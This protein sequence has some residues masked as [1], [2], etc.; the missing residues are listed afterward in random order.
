[1]EEA[2]N[3]EHVVQIPVDKCTLDQV[4]VYTVDRAELSRTVDVKADAAGIYLVEVVGGSLR[5][6][7][8][9]VRVKAPAGANATILEV[10]VERKSIDVIAD[11]DD[12][13]DRAALREDIE[14]LE[15]RLQAIS[16]ED[17]RVKREATVVH[18]YCMGLAESSGDHPLPRLPPSELAKAL[19]FAATRT[20]TVDSRK[21][22]LRK[23]RVLLTK[24]LRLTKEK[25]ANLQPRTQRAHMIIRVRVR[26]DAPT[27]LPLTV[28][29]F[30][31]GAGWAPSF[32]ARVD[33]AS[34]GAGSKGG[35]SNL[36]MQLTYYALVTNNT[37]ED[38]ENC[39]VAL[40][41]A[42]PSAGG[43]PPGV[44]SIEVRW[45]RRAPRARPRP[46]PPPPAAPA[47]H[48]VSC[49][50][51]EMTCNALVA[52]D[53]VTGFGSRA[54]LEDEDDEVEGLAVGTAAVGGGGDTHAGAARFEVEHRTT[55]N[56]SSSHKVTI[57]VLDLEA[58]CHHFTAP[59]VEPCAYLQSKT[60][61]SSP[62]T[63]LKSTNCAVYVDG[64]FVCKSV[65]PQTM[66]GE[67]FTLFLGPDPAV[68]VDC[69]PAVTKDAIVGESIF[70]G[71]GAKRIDARRTV[72]VTNTRSD[73]TIRLHLALTMPRSAD[74]KIKV[75]SIT[76]P[77]QEIKRSDAA[78]SDAAA[79]GSVSAAQGQIAVIQNRITNNLVWILG[80]PAGSKHTVVHEYR[81]EHPA[82]K[83]E[84]DFHELP[85]VTVE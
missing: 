25:L 44:P 37:G 81:V 31:R 8:D 40:S 41:T 52:E 67:S 34:S 80:V 28:A 50:Q 16:D 78:G 20:A 58:A 75:T 64:S 82:D 65:L 18:T 66:P 85:P 1:M 9:S 30:L 46:V 63:L 11:D 73:R 56:D 5:L 57:A 13:P 79:E 39:K 14:A 21:H 27:N 72:L 12:A 70:A 19:D 77:P 48:G 26:V 35:G 43:L 24:E 51:A 42:Q 3:D 32:D 7:E 29:Y 76:P 17:E 54:A 59:A 84:I 36:A 62:Y 53:A 68:K 47:F 38:W 74:D 33:T 60:L 10:G 69:R 49:C 45:A 4:V 22:D 71:K 2:A 15:D 61:N 83:G 55:V 6:D 23:K